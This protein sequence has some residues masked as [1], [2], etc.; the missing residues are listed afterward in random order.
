MIEVQRHRDDSSVIMQNGNDY[1]VGMVSRHNDIYVKTKPEKIHN[2]TSDGIYAF[3]DGV[4][5]DVPKHFAYFKDLGFSIQEPTCS[6]IVKAVYMKWDMDFMSH[7]EGEFACAVWD[8]NNRKLVLARDPYGHKPLHY[9]AD[10]SRFIFASEIKGIL[11]GG[12]SA[13]IDIIAFSD[14]LSLNCIP[15][16]ATIFKNIKQVSPG[17]MMI[18]TAKG[19][20]NRKYYEHKFNVDGSLNLEDSV[21][22]VSN[23][24]KNAVKKRMV[25]KDIYCFLSG[26]ID[27]SAL[28][29]FAAELSS[30][31][32]NAITCS[33]AESEVDELDYAI[34]MAKHVGA[35][36]QHVVAKPDSFFDMLD[37]LVYHHD[38]PFTDTSSYP[39]YYAA[40]LA[41]KF[42]DVI[43]TGDGPDQTMGGSGHHV[44][45]LRNDLFAERNRALQ[46]VYRFTAELLNKFTREPNST[47]FSKIVRKLY[48]DSYSPVHA[49]YDL[50]SFFPNMVKKFICT[51]DLWNIHLEN[52]PYR[53]PESWFQEVSG[54]DNINRYLYADIKFY[55]VDDLM[56]KVDRMCMAHGLETISPFQ[57]IQLAK[58]VNKLPGKYKI[59]FSLNGEITT[60]YILKKV[61]E[62]RFPKSILTKK[63]QGFGIPLEKWLRHDKGQYLQ[64]ILLDTKTL[65][66]GYF[67]KRNVIKYVQD[68]LSG[69]GDYYYASASAI[70]GLITLELWHRKYID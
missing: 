24:I 7:L 38:S 51:D 69:R 48:R 1:A 49:A 21:S 14:F 40:K 54:E 18:I 44:F 6:S 33:F 36:H 27:S 8:E 2:H 10:S 23:E 67:K 43:L 16:P 46:S 26:G 11:K 30:Q 41:R 56:I 4:V 5:L 66:R 64:D 59:N 35:K 45:A 31:P 52:D 39:T 32:V 65:N 34:E 28:I 12:I 47:V 19:V 60:K 22:Q 9:Y 37:T 42:T 20:T 63:K 3:V 70:V 55:V 15:Y 17:D 68:F 29:S 58:V 13:E 62:N 50:R 61:C 53:Y 25:G 57:D